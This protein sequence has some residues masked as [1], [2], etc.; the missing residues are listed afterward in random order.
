MR[1]FNISSCEL[2]KLIHER[3]NIMIKSA[4]IIGYEVAKSHARSVAAVSRASIFTCNVC[5]CSS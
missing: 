4:I 5:S 2:M 1:M 3:N